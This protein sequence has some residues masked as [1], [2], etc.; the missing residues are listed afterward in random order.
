MK[1]RIRWID[2]A[3]LPFGVDKLAR[4]ISFKKAMSEEDYFVDDNQ[5]DENG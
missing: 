3:L 2:L 5:D 4:G 1:S